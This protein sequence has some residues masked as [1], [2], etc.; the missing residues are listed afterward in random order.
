MKKKI[1]ILLTLCLL[2]LSAVASAAPEIVMPEIYRQ[3]GTMPVYRAV[4]RDFGKGPDPALF[5]Q[6][7]IKKQSKHEIVFCDEATLGLDP[8]ALYYSE[9]K[10]FFDCNAVERERNRQ[11]WDAQTLEKE[12]PVSMI[13]LPAASSRIA[14]LASWAYFGFPGTGEVFEPEK[15]ALTHLTLKE[16]EQTLDALLQKL[17]VSGYRPYRWLDMSVERIHTLGAKLNQAIET[18]K[19]GTNIPPFDYATAQDADEGFYLR[20]ARPGLERE[21]GGGSSFQ[22]T[23]Y[24]T[25]RGVVDLDL[26]D[27][28]IQGEVYDTPKK[29]I[30]VQIALDA[31]PKAIAASRNAHKVVSIEKAELCYALLRAPNK[32]DGMVFSPVWAI[33]YQD[34]ESRAAGNA[35]SSWAEFSALDGKLVDAIFN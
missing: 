21:N 12:L 7:G 4:K 31:L 11:L 34:E 15:D 19:L 6:S 9:N 25:R 35:Y 28:Y 16:A 2:V 20:Y 17:G 5:N 1:G 18:G 33:T 14:S 29:L 23:A 30:D 22:V 3:T 10:G 32:K 24:V 8:A 26:N 27:P 13:P